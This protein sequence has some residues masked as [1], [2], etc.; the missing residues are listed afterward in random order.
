M[1]RVSRLSGISLALVCGCGDQGGGDVTMDGGAATTSGA[2]TSTVSG[3]GMTGTG[4]SGSETTGDSATSDGTIA[5]ACAALCGK[6]IECML[7][8]DEDEYCMYDCVETVSM[9]L[10]GC[11]PLFEAWL[12]CLVG[13]TCEQLADY[14]D[15]N[16]SDVCAQEDQALEAKECWDF[17]C[18]DMGTGF[19][20]GKDECTMARECAGGP[21]YKIECDG[22]LCVCLLDGV[23][24]G[25]SCPAEMV[26]QHSPDTLREKGEQ[27]CEFPPIPQE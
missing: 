14:Y 18:S 13:L 17:G 6:L 4:T 21:E 7:D 10:A 9:S 11:P 3:Q 2:T 23:P 24:T 22:Q 26:C 1:C 5:N 8:P 27:C 19:V 12:A 15:E 25:I 20:D 16:T